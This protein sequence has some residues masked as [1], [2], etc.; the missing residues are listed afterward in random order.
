MKANVDHS[1]GWRLSVRRVAITAQEPGTEQVVQ[2]KPFVDHPGAVAVVPLQRT[3]SGYDVVM[4]RQYRM[5][6]ERI[7]LEIPAGTR[8]PDEPFLDCARRE[9]REETGMAAETLLPLGEIWPAPGISNERMALYLAFGL[10]PD[11]LPADD[12]EQI[13]LETHALSELVPAALDGR[14]EDGKSVVALLRTAHYLEANA[15]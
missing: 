5:T 14:L 8:E 2:Y 7:I 13:T 1:G 9:L 12:D 11:P 3:D 4:V 6:L 10:Y 15:L